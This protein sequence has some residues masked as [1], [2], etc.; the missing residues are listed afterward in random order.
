MV[1]RI[2]M[3]RRR[4]RSAVLTLRMTN[5]E[6]LRFKLAAIALGKKRAKIVR[7]RVADLIG[8]ALP[9]VAAVRENTVAPGGVVTGGKKTV[10]NCESVA[11]CPA[12]ADVHR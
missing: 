4:V 9:G 3:E 2:K 6:M 10:I 7:E 5:E 11:E 12:R 8:M 1:Q